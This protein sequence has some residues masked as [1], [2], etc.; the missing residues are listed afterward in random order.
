LTRVAAPTLPVTVTNEPP[1]RS[2]NQRWPAKTASAGTSSR[3]QRAAPP[4][5]S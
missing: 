3:K 2:V 1:R 5:M 4:R